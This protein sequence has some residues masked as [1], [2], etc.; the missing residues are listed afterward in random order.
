MGERAGCREGH[1]WL[2]PFGAAL[3]GA[4]LS[5]MRWARLG[6]GRR[7]PSVAGTEALRPPLRL[8]RRAFG[9]PLRWGGRCCRP[10]AMPVSYSIARGPCFGRCWVNTEYLTCLG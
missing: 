6:G 8:R 1:T 9:V 2:R 7:V 3:R 10:G 5:E 4:R